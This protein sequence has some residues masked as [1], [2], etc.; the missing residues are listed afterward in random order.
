MRMILGLDAPSSGRATVNGRP[1]SEHAAPLTEIGALLDAKA[2]HPKRSARNHHRA[3]A[4]TTGISDRRVDEVIGL[5][6]L[7]DVADRAAGTSRSAWANGSGSP[8]RS[9]THVNRASSTSTTGRSSS[10]SFAYQT[11]LVRPPGS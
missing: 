9:K 5:V 2:V 3:L 8:P 11:G 4:A 6:G 10:S 7:E 1:L